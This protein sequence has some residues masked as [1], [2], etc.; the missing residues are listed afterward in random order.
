MARP[1]KYPWEEIEKVYATGQYT[2]AEI[3]RKYGIPSAT[4]SEQKTKR[5]FKVSEIA[6]GIIKASVEVSESFRSISEDDSEMASIIADEVQRVSALRLKVGTAAELILNRI[7]EQVKHGKKQ[8]IV[9]TK[10]Y[11]DG[12]VDGESADV[13]EIDH[14]PKDLKDLADAVDKTAITLGV[15]QRH[16]NAPQVAI[17]N[18]NTAQSAVQVDQ[19]TVKSIQAI[20]EE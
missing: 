7:T 8:I 1:S 3:C 16:A 10:E 2:D 12:R 6:S 17:Q 13:V 15:A 9:K 20:L 14:E 5:K 18:N 11:V 19:S 4:F